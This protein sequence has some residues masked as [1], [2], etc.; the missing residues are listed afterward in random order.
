VPRK[1]VPAGAGV[2]GVAH[3]VE[4]GAVGLVEIGVEQHVGG[5]H[6]LQRGGGP[7]GACGGGGK[8]VHHVGQQEP[9]AVGRGRPAR[10]GGTA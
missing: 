10:S 9:L 7:V 1:Q 5:G 6:A 4:Q 2:E 3:E 8:L